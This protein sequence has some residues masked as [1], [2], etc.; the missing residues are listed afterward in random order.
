MGALNLRKLLGAEDWVSD[1]TKASSSVLKAQKLPTSTM[2]N[3]K[4]LTTCLRAH[5]DLQP[6]RQRKEATTA[7]QQLGQTTILARQR[8]QDSHRSITTLARQ[9]EQNP[10]RS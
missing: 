5:L 9:H 1:L 2:G 10:H 6:P 8:K 3:M 4:I 7:H